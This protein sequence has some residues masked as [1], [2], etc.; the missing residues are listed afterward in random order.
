M[1]YFVNTIPIYMASL[2]ALLAGI[3]TILI[4]TTGYITAFNSIKRGRRDNHPL[5]IMAGLL[6]AGMGSL[7]LGTNVSFISLL[8]TQQNLPKNVVGQLCYMWAPITISIGVYVGMNVINQKYAKGFTIIYGLSIPFYLYGLFIDAENTIGADIPNEIGG[9]LID[10]NLLSYIKL[11]TAVYLVS[12]LLV[13]GIGFLL[14]GLKSAGAVRRKGF[15]LATGYNLFVVCGAIDSLVDF[16]AFI[17]VVRFF[18]MSAYVLLY[19]GFTE[20]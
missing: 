11:L 19:R 1:F 10:I 7:Y 3:T 17:V 14:L 15:L 20:I 18:M 16:S 6:L 13:L 2:N 4:T 9:G 12:T 5:L 8:I